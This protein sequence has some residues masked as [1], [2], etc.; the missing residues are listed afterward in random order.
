MDDT[1]KTNL[2]LHQMACRIAKRADNKIYKKEFI[3]D[4][5][6]LFADEIQEAILE[7]NGVRIDEVGVIKPDVK[8]RETYSLPFCN[9]PEGNPPYTTF[10]M[11]R[12]QKFKDKMNKKLLENIE[13][14]IY[15]LENLPFTKSQMRILK[16]TGFI[17]DDAD[18]S[19]D[20]E[21]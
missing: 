1:K 3:Y 17:P 5:L 6:K 21:E 2:S 19:D 7:G 10:K 11:T 13:N 16:N 9:K 14:G 12:S 15:G 8:V 18:I 4:I 20:E